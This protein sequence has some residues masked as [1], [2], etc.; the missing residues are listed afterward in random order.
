MNLFRRS[1]LFSLFAPFMASST[2]A[3]ALR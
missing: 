2:A 1:R 3:T